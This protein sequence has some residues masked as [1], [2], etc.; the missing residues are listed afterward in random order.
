M[1][2]APVAMTDEVNALMEKKTTHARFPS[3]SCLS[4]ESANAAVVNAG[5]K[6]CGKTTDICKT[7][8]IAASVSAEGDALVVI[9][10]MVLLHQRSRELSIIHPLQG[11]NGVIFRH[12]RPAISGK[13]PHNKEQDHAALEYPSLCA[14]EPVRSSE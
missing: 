7:P 13:A 8:L 14:A 9:S 4:T 5:V 12:S 10:A 3:K 2:L 6:V 11:A 1:T